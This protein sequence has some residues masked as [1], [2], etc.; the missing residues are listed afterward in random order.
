VACPGGIMTPDIANLACPDWPPATWTGVV[1]R[2][3]PYSVLVV[4]SR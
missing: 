1:E 3:K 4:L 2:P